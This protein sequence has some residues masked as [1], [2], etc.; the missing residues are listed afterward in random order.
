MANT[1]WSMCGMCSVRCPIKVLVENDDVKWIE[2]NPNILKGAL[3]AKG[4]AGH[5]L[6]TDDER[7]KTPLIRKGL[8]GSG[9][10][11]SVSW[12]QAFEY[13]ADKLNAI[14]K[15]YGPE[16]VMLS[17]RG[18]PFADLFKAF[19]HA[20]GSP[21][22]SNH[23][24]ACG[25]NVHH[26]AKTIYGLGRK[27]LAYDIKNCKHLI[28]FGRNLFEALR[29]AEANQVMDMLDN[30][31]RLTY[32][33]VR[34]TI[35]GTKATRFFMVRPGTDYALTLGMINEVLNQDAYDKE[36]VAKYTVGFDE[37]CKFIEPYT[38]DWAAK[39]CGIKAN[40]LKA[41]VK[42]I[43][44]DRP[45]VIFHPGWML[46]RYHDSFYASRSLQILNVLMGNIEVEGGQIFAKG[47][48]D[49]GV[50]GLQSL[51]AQIPKPK[52]PRADGVGTEYNH[53]DKGPGIF[54]LFYNAMETGK[55]YPIKALICYRH[56]P[57]NCF[58]DP[59]AQKKAMENVDL[60]VSIDTHYSEFG[61]YSDVILPESTYLER[62]NPIATQK[63]P[64]PRFIVRQRAVTPRND[65]KAGWE[66]FKGLA[67]KL[68]IGQYFP[69]NSAEEMWKWQLEPTGHT[70]EEFNE[71]G[72]IPLTDKPIFYD[73]DNLEGK[74]KTPSGK[75]EIISKVLQDQGL[76]SLKEY[77]SP[78]KPPKGQFRLVFGRTA[79]HAHGH[80]INNP[81]L[82]ELLPENTLWINTR[83][84]SR[85]DI[86]DGDLVDVMA[87]GAKETIKARVTDFIHPEAVYMMHG[88][89]RE[90]PVQTRTYRVGASDQ[91][92]QIGLLHKTDPAGGGLC[93]CEK[94][95]TVKKSVRNAKRRVEL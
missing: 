82:N 51:D 62:E 68:G 33:D 52:A 81:L 22:F 31:G 11:E 39:E 84:A 34:Q 16:S 18:G 95:V 37:L 45:R 46:S 76:P 47:P 77:E 72:F 44:E 28:L 42:E 2:G 8:R 69:F 86:K 70:P 6:L 92:L 78:E 23:D 67:D 94:F 7:P 17:C 25:R 74:F 10:W 24:S 58:P 55:P 60:L 5:A 53:W 75:I 85:M 54:H 26:A 88:F 59:E 48:G 12:E 80:T 36:F 79:V 27:G 19:I 71:K 73:R 38:A 90:V 15:L 20:I 21:N 43:K 64:K 3:C 14:K 91:K 40:A 1:I 35:T 83:V 65:T 66:I 61:W 41:F 49:C 89:G 4:S 56:D 63:G 93:L 30:G 13:V 50:K 32:V 57:F 9:Q 29:L 87:N